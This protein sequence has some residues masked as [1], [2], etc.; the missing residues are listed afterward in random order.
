V[1]VTV[2]VLVT[3]PPEP[4]AVSVYVVVCAGVTLTDPLADTPPTIGVIDTD[5]AFA[6]L[7]AKE[8]DWPAVTDEGDTVSVAVGADGVVDDV[9]VGSTTNALNSGPV[10]G[11]VVVPPIGLAGV[12]P[13]IGRVTGPPLYVAVRT[14]GP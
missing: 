1:T 14:A 2:A 4:A 10:G 5:V 13:V 3:V 12:S 6:V 9:P 8:A 11:A 7:H